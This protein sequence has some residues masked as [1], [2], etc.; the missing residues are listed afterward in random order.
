MTRRRAWRAAGW[1]VG[2]AVLI[3]T[4][5]AL[6]GEYRSIA[7]LGRPP[8]AGPTLAAF[9]LNVAANAALVGGWL[10][11]LHTTVTRLGWRPALWVWAG[12]QLVRYGLGGAQIGGRVVLARRYG[13]P[14]V[15]AGAS[16]LV[17]TLWQQSLNA[18]VLL[19]TIGWWLPAARSLTGVAAAA[20]VPVAIL[21]AGLVAPRRLLALLA[22]VGRLRPLRRLPLERLER[23][24][25]TRRAAAAATL[26]F[27][28]NTALRSIGFVALF[29][30]VGGAWGDWPLAV[31]AY[32]LGK[33]VGQ[34]AAFV[35]GGIGPREGA[36][37]LAVAPALGG[38]PA[39]LLVAAARL[40]EIAAEVVFAGAARVQR[41]PAVEAAGRTAG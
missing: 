5:W 20:A 7:E 21:V 31:G 15:T 10:A 6:A 29:T 24:A 41:P 22:A 17:E 40:V 32:M 38:G 4:G 25:M 27:G 30:A 23:V 35:P 1:L 34:A 9:V 2:V 18:A 14:P 16:A 37:A 11:V 36:T 8:P 39:L 26:W 33:L 28:A 19:A 13:V 3:A 12:S